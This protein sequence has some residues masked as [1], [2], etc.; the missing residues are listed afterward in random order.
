MDDDARAMFFRDGKCSRF[1]GV[2]QDITERKTAEATLRRQNRLL[3]R[4]VRDRTRERDRTWSLS[5]DLMIVCDVATRAI[6][7]NPAWT[8]LLGWTENDLLGKRAIELVHPEDKDTLRLNSERGDDDTTRVECRISRKD[9]GYRWVEW[10]TVSQDALI[11]AIGGDVTEAK[12]ANEEIAAANRQLVRQIEEHEKVE[13]TLRQMQRLEAVGQLTAGVAH[14]FNNLLS[15][16]LGNVALLHREMSGMEPRLIRR[17][18]QVNKAAE[19]G[20]KLTAQLLAFSRRQRLEPKPVDLN[21]TVLGMRDLLQS[22]MG[23][24]VRLR[25]G[26][27]STLWFALVDPTQI[28]L[29]IL[30]LAINARDAMQGGGDLI[31]ATSNTTLSTSPSR[32]EEPPRGEYVMLTVSDTGSGMSDEV[33]QRAFEPFFT[34]KE[35]GKGSGLGL[36]QV[37]GFVKQSGGG[38]RVET[39]VGKGTSIHVFLPRAQP[40]TERTP[41]AL[42]VPANRTLAVQGTLILLVDDDSAVREITA[43]MLRDL[44]YDVVE[45]GSGGAAL[46]LLAREP[47][48]SLSVLDYA[49]PGMS[50]AEVAHEVLKRRPGLPIVFITGYV[51]LT[52]L[53]EVGEDR[54]VQKPFREADL[55]DKIGRSLRMAYG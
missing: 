45:A 4:E 3:A 53:K 37:F 16:V 42:D 22:T 18:D 14:D 29:I 43:K 27:A 10:T 26:L 48:I 54:I 12:A 8:R 34:T 39:E 30:N 25:T 6:A 2:I 11:Y 44:G 32:P 24:S 49:M 19:R 1:V 40:L 52:A 7:V 47:R 33:R 20:A 23:G 50:G 36:A 17:L 38:I 9:G 13:T 51:D 41:E 15:V 5:R 55:A 28:E 31:V 21:D 35:I 46:D